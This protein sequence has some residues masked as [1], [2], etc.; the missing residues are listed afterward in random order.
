VI[1]R[2]G[3][4]RREGSSE[5]IES[6]LLCQSI[7]ALPAQITLR[8]AIGVTIFANITAKMCEID[9]NSAKPRESY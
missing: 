2:R 5:A 4:W 1:L 9:K 7:R 6:V 3:R 8:H